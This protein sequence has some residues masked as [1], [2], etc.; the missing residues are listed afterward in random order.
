M[1]AIRIHSFGGPDVL[2]LEQLPDP[3]PGPGEILV[4]VKA[5]GINPVDAYIRAGSYGDRKFPFT[6][7]M[8]AAGTVAGIGTGVTRFKV[9]DRVYV[10]GSLSGTYAELALCKESQVHPLLSS[11]SFEQGAAIGVPYATAYYALFNRGHA[12]PAK[13]FLFTG[14]PAAWARRR[15]S[16]RARA[17]SS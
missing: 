13:L 10:A 5:A 15:C 14:R 6:P 12:M 11:I 2:V 7:G 8:D 4:R 17:G 9:N 1:K 3:T 16:S